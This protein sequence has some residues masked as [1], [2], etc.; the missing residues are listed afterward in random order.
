MSDTLPRPTARQLLKAVFWNRWGAIVGTILGV[1]GVLDFID[2]HFAPRFPEALKTVWGAYYVLPSFGW[3]TWL[4]IVAAGLTVVA[5]H[6]AYVFAMGYSKRYEDLTKN[7]VIFEL[8][9]VSTRVFVIRD[10]GLITAKLKLRFQNK[11]PHDEHLR[12]LRLSLHDYRQ[13]GEILTWIVEDRYFGLNG[14]IEM[15]ILRQGFEGMSI[16]AKRLTPWYIAR[17]TIDVMQEEKIRIP[18]RLT[19]SHYLMV[20][21]DVTN[22]EPFKTRIFVNWEKADNKNGV[23]ILSIGAP[24]IRRFED[25]RILEKSD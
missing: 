11:E 18:E 12:T 22:Q 24:A 17:I 7:K 9:E 23:P 10:P 2:A 6:S 8:D 13:G 19:D 21:M 4:V 1:F 16:Q 25:R 3:R 15:E 14:P 5:I 20:T